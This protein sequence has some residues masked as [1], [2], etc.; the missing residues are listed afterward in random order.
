[1]TYSVRKY[2]SA[3]SHLSAS[4]VSSE[5]VESFSQEVRTFPPVF[6]N[7][8][9]ESVSQERASRSVPGVFSNLFVYWYDTYVDSTRTCNR[10]LPLV[11]E[12]FRCLTCPS[13]SYDYH[14]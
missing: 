1:M 6:S 10:V 12:F 5:R 11:I 7:F 3:L 8:L 14:V 4:S 2:K 9:S 13:K